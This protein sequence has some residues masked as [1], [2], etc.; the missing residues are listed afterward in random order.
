M[1][2]GETRWVKG[3]NPSHIDRFVMIQGLS[4]QCEYFGL[5]LGLLLP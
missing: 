5:I 1:D 4:Y 3:S 2:P